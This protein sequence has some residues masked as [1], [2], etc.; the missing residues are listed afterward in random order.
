MGGNFA[1]GLAPDESIGCLALVD[2]QMKVMNPG[3]WFDFANGTSGGLTDTAHPTQDCRVFA[4]Q[5]VTNGYIV[6]VAFN[7]FNGDPISRGVMKLQNNLSLDSNFATGLLG[8]AGVDQSEV[9]TIK[10]LDNNRLIVGGNFTSFHG[11]AAA[12]LAMIDSTTGSITSGSDNRAFVSRLGHS[13]AA[14]FSVN[15]VEVLNPDDPN[16]N[17]IVAGHFNEYRLTSPI[18]E[19]GNIIV[20]DQSGTRIR[21]NNSGNN[22]FNQRNIGSGFNGPVYSLDRQTDGKIL[23]GG[24]FSTYNGQPLVSK[25]LVR[26]NADGTLDDTFLGKTK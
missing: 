23:V 8:A 22:G 11:A 4:L 24:S 13:N 3:R 26:L 2:D 19:V 5:K 21:L 15:D 1:V 6:G 16:S 17:L 14:D 7:E 25:N 18:T 12:G 20:L 9:R 10:T